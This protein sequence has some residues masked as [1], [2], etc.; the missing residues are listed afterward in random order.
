MTAPA[1]A[2]GGGRRRFR[3][4][5][6]TKLTRCEARQAHGFSSRV[7]NRWSRIRFFPKR[8][9]FGPFSNLSLNTLWRFRLHAAHFMLVFNFD[10]YAADEKRPKDGSHRSGV[11]NRCARDQIPSRLTAPTN[12]LL[13]FEPRR[14]E[15]KIGELRDY[16]LFGSFKKTAVGPS[17]RILL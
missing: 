5:A 8:V 14:N 3:E 12:R 4:I 13:W 10:D 16:R 9:S 7:V 6:T 1:S 2:R 15:S 17:L 11:F